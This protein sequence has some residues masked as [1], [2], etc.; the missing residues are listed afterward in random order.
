MLLRELL[1]MLKHQVMAFASAEA[2]LDAFAPGRFGSLVTDMQLP[3]MSGLALADTLRQA[4]PVIDVIVASGV[5]Q[6]TVA[7]RRPYTCLA[8]P[9]DIDQMD[10]L[11]RRAASPA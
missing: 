8:K 9:Y 11:L 1:G 3:G 10:A 6:V 4:D 2:A 7:G 5:G